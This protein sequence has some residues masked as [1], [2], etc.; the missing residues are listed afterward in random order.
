[1]KR[2]RNGPWHPRAGS[3]R[4]RQ[5]RGGHSAGATRQDLPVR[6]ANSVGSRTHR[7]GKFGP[8][9]AFKQCMSGPTPMPEFSALAPPVA[10]VG[11]PASTGV[12][13]TFLDLLAGAIGA[14][15]SRASQTDARTSGARAVEPSGPAAG[16]IA[17]PLPSRQS[18][19]SV[20]P[21]DQPVPQ[22]KPGSGASQPPYPPGGECAG[23]GRESPPALA[24]AGDTPDPSSAGPIKAP[25][26]P[27]APNRAKPGCMPSH[28]HSA[29]IKCAIPPP[30]A[31]A[32]TPPP[33][34]V[35]LPPPSQ[36]APGRD[37]LPAAGND[38]ATLD[39]GG[40][41][42]DPRRVARMVATDALAPAKEAETALAARPTGV[43]LAGLFRAEIG[44]A[45]AQTTALAPP[46][47]ASAAPA[48]PARAEPTAS[49]AGPPASP[50]G[51]PASPHPPARTPAAQVAPVMV[52]LASGGAGTHRLV[53][54]LDPPE[55]GRL[56]IRVTRSQEAGPRI[57]VTIERP[58]T[59]ALVRQDAPALHQALSDAGV[60]PEGRRVTIQLGQPGGHDLAGHGGG[61]QEGSPRRFSAASF[62]PATGTGA[63]ETP[64]ALL[65]LVLRN[66]L[67]ITA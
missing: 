16:L 56:E 51:P 7:R 34:P 47:V 37:V 52:S 30:D 5:R 36:P 9:L 55:L 57:E 54:H 42:A 46:A 20:R 66:A 43:S 27:A 1:M 58:A 2:A 17:P 22:G 18:F 19:G 67:D 33:I 25:K 59:L 3:G 24:V 15:V 44:E 48:Q 50:A 14:P 65:R 13:G 40:M 38:N 41:K 10:P 31:D 49:P 45:G 60:P 29:A 35:A 6:I 23:A 64:P 26:P 4:P 61:G 8:K 21:R 63:A 53:L 11:N 12:A 28:A 32:S 62:G 39:G